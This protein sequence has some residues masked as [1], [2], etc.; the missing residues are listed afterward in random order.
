MSKRKDNKTKIQTVIDRN[1]V[2]LAA[3]IDENYIFT[4]EDKIQI[5]YDEYTKVRKGSGDFWTCFGIFL[6]LFITMITCDFKAVF[7]IDTPTIRAIFIISMLASVG[8]CVYF[9]LGWIKNREKLKFDYFIKK[10]KGDETDEK[11]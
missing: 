2:S 4:T 1:G 5:L 11:Y 3:N 10:I 8:F 7:F 6:T 9:V